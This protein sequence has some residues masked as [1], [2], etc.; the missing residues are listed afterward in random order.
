MA[1]SELNPLQ[2]QIDKLG[3]EVEAVALGAG[4]FTG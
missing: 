2:A 1:D 3:F 4:Y